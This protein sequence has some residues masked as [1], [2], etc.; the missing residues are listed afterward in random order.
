MWTLG[1]WLFSSHIKSTA[2]GP[3]RKTWR[4]SWA[5]SEVGG[6]CQQQLDH[7]YH[8]GFLNFECEFYF[9]PP[10]VYCWLLLLPCEDETCRMALIVTCQDVVDQSVSCRAQTVLRMIS[11]SLRCYLN[12]SPPVLSSHSKS[13]KIQLSKEDSFKIE[14]SLPKWLTWLPQ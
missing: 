14:V 7:L 3:S 5:V 6:C 9:L 10:S 1:I 8:L 13:S 2:F 11:P 4:A 12:H